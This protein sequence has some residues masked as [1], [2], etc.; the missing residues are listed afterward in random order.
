MPQP[1]LEVARVRVRVRGGRGRGGGGDQGCGG[2]SCRQVWIYKC[3]PFLSRDLSPPAARGVRVQRPALPPR[4]LRC[5]PTTSPRVL[6]DPMAYFTTPQGH[7]SPVGRVKPPHPRRR[8]LVRAL[9]VAL[10][11]LAGTYTPLAASRPRGRASS[12]PPSATL[13][14]AA[15]TVRSGAGG[16]GG[17]Y[18]KV[19]GAHGGVRPMAPRRASGRGAGV[20]CEAAQRTALLL[21]GAYPRRRARQRRPSPQALTEGAEAQLRSKRPR[22]PR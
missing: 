17:L 10:V 22:T 14:C 15:R 9:Q 3:K 16:R 5:S 4:C 1:T 2:G 18:D 6:Y 20:A 21:Q 11:L 19:R 13:T 7:P 8:L 12:P